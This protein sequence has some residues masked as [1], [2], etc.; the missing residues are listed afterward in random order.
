MI[1]SRM[2]KVRVDVCVVV[3]AVMGLNSNHDYHQSTPELYSLEL[4]NQK[5]ALKGIYK[6]I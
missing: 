1:N 4:R 3:A 5:V 2:Q 6:M